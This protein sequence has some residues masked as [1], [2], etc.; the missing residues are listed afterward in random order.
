MW[1]TYWSGAV[2]LVGW[3]IMLPLGISVYT[4][5]WL[6]ATWNFFEVF[7]GKDFGAWFMGPFRRAF[8]GSFIIYPLGVINS[9]IPGWGILTGWLCGWWANADYYDYIEPWHIGVVAAAEEAAA[10]EEATTE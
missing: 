9:I 10:S 3:V 6:I 1:W 5:L 2:W 8:V 4:W 7:G